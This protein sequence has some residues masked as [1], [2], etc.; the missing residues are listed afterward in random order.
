M[1]IS[2]FLFYYFVSGGKRNVRRQRAQ[3]VIRNT[4]ET[5]AFVRLTNFTLNAHA[6]IDKHLIGKDGKKG[7]SAVGKFEK[8]FKAS[9]FLFVRD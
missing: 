7:H 5:E 8:K 2:L 3:P 6:W 4:P 9:I 1:N